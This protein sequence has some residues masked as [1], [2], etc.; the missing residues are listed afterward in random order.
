M[1]RVQ[2][3][4]AI[5]EELRRHAP[6]PVSAATLAARFSVSRR[7]IERD[8][9]ALRHAGV[10]VYGELGRHGGQSVNWGPAGRRVQFSLSA[11]E[12]TALLVASTA[13]GA[14]I[15]F[16]TAG[17]VAVDRLLDALP[18]DTRLG[19]DELRRRIR[20][21]PPPQ[22]RPRRAVQRTVEEAVRRAVVVNLRYLDAE[23]VSTERAV[24]A[25]G[26]YGSAAGWYLIGWCEL[27]R[28]GRIF[29]LDRIVA[30]RLTRRANTARDLD[31]VLGWV[32]GEVV[33]P[34]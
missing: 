16:G 24:E 22:L 31:A 19:V 28:G 15:P 33:T 8:L 34:A 11:E 26:F 13:A 2:R 4:Y 3:L 12:V 21:E 25:H 1:E 9:V 27:R 29:R 30:A 10:P 6:R 17:R 23:G 7:T 20:T 5:S 32:P 14:D 18:P